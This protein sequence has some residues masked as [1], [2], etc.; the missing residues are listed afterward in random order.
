MKHRESEQVKGT[1][2]LGPKGKVVGQT[3]WLRL[4]SSPFYPVHSKQLREAIVYHVRNWGTPRPHYRETGSEN[5]TSREGG[6][7]PRSSQRPDGNRLDRVKVGQE[8]CTRKQHT[9]LTIGDVG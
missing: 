8:G 7:R 4:V 5:A 3:L 2:T 6:R 1:D 9:T